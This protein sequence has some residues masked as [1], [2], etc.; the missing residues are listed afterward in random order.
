MQDSSNDAADVRRTVEYRTD[1]WLIRKVP[2]YLLL[3]LAGLALVM[4]ADGRGRVGGW[5]LLAA[6]AGLV[7]FA[8]YRQAHPGRPA[9]TLSPG[10]LL[11]RAG[12]KA[13]LVAWPEVHGVDTVDLKV[14]TSARGIPV[15]VRYR[16]CTVVLVSKAFY[17]AHLDAGFLRGPA[18]GHVFVPRGD[19]VQIALHHEQLSVSPQDVRGP[20]EARWRASMGCLLYT[21]P[22]PRD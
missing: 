1:T 4:Y 16:D 6:G 19:M 8:L 12:R 21:S 13:T 14:R 17:E 18:W 22:S 15:T 3:C 9:L 7:G 2:L 11:L 20:I 5:V 10:G